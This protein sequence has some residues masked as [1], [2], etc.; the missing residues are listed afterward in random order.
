MANCCF[1]ERNATV[2]Q[3]D[4]TLSVRHSVFC[5]V[6]GRFGLHINHNLAGLCGTALT[7]HQA[8]VPLHLMLVF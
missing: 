2:R 8:D 6:T 1:V 5:N 3:Y 4:T 7:L